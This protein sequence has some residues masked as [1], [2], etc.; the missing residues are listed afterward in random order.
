MRGLVLEGGGVRGLYTAGVLDT[1]MENGIEFDGIIGVS[2]GACF[3]PNFLSNQKGRAIRY[4][5]RFNKSHK[6]MGMGSLIFTGN[7]FN[8]KLAY[9]VVPRKIDVFDDETF[10]KSNVPF[11]AV[12]TN[13]RTGKAEYKQINSVFE[14]M[15]I[16]RASASMP[17]VSTPVQLGNDLYLDGAIADS[18]PYAEFHKMGYDEL[19][20]VLTK[21][22]EYI[23]KPVNKLL[24]RL[25]YG[26]KYPKMAKRLEKRHIEYNRTRVRLFDLEEKGL[27]KIIAP[28]KEVPV[29]R[30][31]RDP[32]R[33]Q[34]LYDLGCQDAKDMIDKL[35]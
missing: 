14:D 25:M 15:D 3:G 7:Y 13:L 26:L 27:I 16:I 2:A 32:E 33:M 23:R 4:N 29:S 20:V 22:R 28:S 17:F 34:R 11:Y 5:K 19:V 1:F 10:K 8:T 21:D 35:K 18:I 31:E 12:V 30:V 24:T 6:Y 9:E